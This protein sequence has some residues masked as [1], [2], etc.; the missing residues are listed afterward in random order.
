VFAEPWPDYRRMTADVVVDRVS[1]GSAA[2]VAMVKLY[3]GSHR[4]RKSVLDAAEMR[5]KALN[6][7]AKR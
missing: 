4:G 5:L 1:E 6:D 2:E 3:E 7:P